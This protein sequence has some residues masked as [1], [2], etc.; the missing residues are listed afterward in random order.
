MEDKTRERDGQKEDTAKQKFRYVDTPLVKAIRYGYL[1][2]IQEP[3]VIANPG[4]L[5]G[6]NPLFDRCRTI[7]L[8]TGERIHRHPN[9]VLMVTTNHDYA[10]CKDINQSV[11]SRMNLVMD[12]EQPEIETMVERVCGITGC[13]DITAVHRM[14][15]A[16]DEISLRCKETMITDGSCG[17]RELIAWVQS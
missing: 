7:E 5:V 15:E 17:M 9:T 1:C 13:K 3:T 2:E 10:G 4:V 12:I 8:P 6:L 16:V 11:I 14:T